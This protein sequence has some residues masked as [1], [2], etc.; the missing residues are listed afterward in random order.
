MGLFV[1]LNSTKGSGLWPISKTCFVFKALNSYFGKID[2]EWMKIMRCFHLRQK[3]LLIPCCFYCEF[4][5]FL[6][7]V[8]ILFVLLVWNARFPASDKICIYECIIIMILR[9]ERFVDGEKW[10]FT[11]WLIVLYFK[12]YGN[13]KLTV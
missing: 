5:Y 2:D 7:I 6:F 10:N 13:G 9:F 1:S 8:C 12:F 4:A 3:N 11:I